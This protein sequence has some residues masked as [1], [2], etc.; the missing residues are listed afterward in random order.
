[1][2]VTTNLAELINKTTNHSQTQ[3][4]IWC[5]YVST[6]SMWLIHPLCRVQSI[7]GVALPFPV[8]PSASC[9]LAF[10]LPS[11]SL[12]YRCCFPA[13]LPMSVVCNLGHRLKLFTHK[14]I[15]YAVFGL[16]KCL[17]SIDFA[18]ANS[19]FCPGEGV[20]NGS[21]QYTWIPYWLPIS[22]IKICS[23]ERQA[24]NHCVQESNL[25]LWKGLQV[26][27]PCATI[28]LE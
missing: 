4:S 10:F 16:A 18:T 25:C 28:K 26:F 13:S 2:K 8:Q 24:W 3:P 11:T 6:N 22:N 19:L 23:N 14:S 20:D 1:M 12:H 9:N 17:S 5:A 27:F 15:I 7:P 21:L